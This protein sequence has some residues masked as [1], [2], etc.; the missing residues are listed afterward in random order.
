MKPLIS[1]IIPV[2]NPDVSLL[3][4]AVASTKDINESEVIIVDDCSNNCWEE[5]MNKS[6]KKGVIIIRNGENKGIYK[7][8]IFST[9]QGKGKYV[10]KLDPDDEIIN[11]HLYYEYLK[12]TDYDIVFHGY[13]YIRKDKT[14]DGSYKFN[15]FN[16]S[17][18]YNKKILEEAK[19]DFSIENKFFFEDI[20][21][22]LFSL[23]KIKN[24][25]KILTIPETI[26]WY[27]QISTT[28]PKQ[29]LNKISD[30][31]IGLDKIL[32]IHSHDKRI[33]KIFEYNIQKLWV[34]GDIIESKVA[35]NFE[36]KSMVWYFKFYSIL[37]RFVK[38]LIK[39]ALL[40]Y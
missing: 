18:I 24:G 17:V 32:E 8:S 33:S 39:W 38:R 37:P 30:W 1:I 2:Y 25:K 26:Y 3:E 22:I 20:H 28:K 12:G 7:N 34:F 13:K 10:K 27:K 16:G 6:L 9:S 5:R 31:D 36:P 35:K 11:G 23:T 4:R 19:R 14:N 29:I 21:Q 15:L 40:K